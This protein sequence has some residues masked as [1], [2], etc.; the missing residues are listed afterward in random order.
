MARQFI[1]NPDYPVVETK[2]GKLRGFVLDG[3]FT[4][5]GIQYAKAARFHMP[6][7][8]DSWEGIKDASSYGCTAPTMAT[9]MPSGE[10]L[11]PHRF[12][13]ENENCQFLNIWSPSIDRSAKK[14]VIVWYHGGGYADGSSIEQ[15]AYEG[16]ALAAYGDAVVVTVNHR[17]NILGFL[18]LSSYGEEYANS[19]NAGMADIVASLQWIHEN[20][21]G[22]GGD[23]DNVTVFG[24]SGGGGKVCTLLQT[25][26]AAGLF[27]KAV[28]MSGGAGSM[29]MGEDVDHK[30]IVD[31]MLDELGFDSVKKL[32]KIPYTLLVKVF[33]RACRKAGHTPGWE[34][35]ANGWYLG[36]PL[37]VGF[38]EYAKKVPT[39]V[40]SVIAEFGGFMPPEDAESKYPGHAEEVFAAFAKAYPDKDRSLVTKIDTW[41]RPGILEFMKKR[42]A[43]APEACGYSYV[44]TLHFD[45]LGGTPAWH[46]SDIPFVFHNSC[47]VGNCNIEGVTERLEEEMAGALIAFAKTGDPNHAGMPEWRPFTETDHAS[48]FFD[49]ESRCEADRDTELIGLAVKYAKPFELHFDVPADEGEE[50]GKLWMY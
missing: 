18:D 41:A 48:M 38:S 20:I 40:S 33:N 5:H 30:I 34:P 23:P 19:A 11:I 14:P 36:H 24:Q 7:E 25:P 10:I 44:F 12:W 16:D 22:F 13:P 45:V 17:L 3:I 35:K 28:M 39:I 2:Y 32:E 1:C 4:F 43:S 37:D 47:R 27:H 15:V 21:E 8:P 9:P 29:K 50:D 6:E 31:I 42:A 46:C 49:R 26:A